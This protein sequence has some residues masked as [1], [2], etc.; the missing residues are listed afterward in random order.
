MRNPA[1]ALHNAAFTKHNFLPEYSFIEPAYHDQGDVLA[2]DQ[3][4]DHD[5]RSGDNFIRQ[6]YQ[7]IR[8]NDDLWKSTVLVV[9]WD[10][11][12]GIFDHEIPPM[13]SHPDGFTSTAPPARFPPPRFQELPP[14]PPPHGR[15]P[16]RDHPPAA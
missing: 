10:E 14:L 11:H 5:V 4:P 12:G 8:S 7:A 6:V 3:H 16:T 13:V 2:C 1:A 9:V 15:R